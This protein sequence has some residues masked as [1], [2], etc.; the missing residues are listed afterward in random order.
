MV[1]ASTAI[2]DNILE[3][4]VDG[5]S[6]AVRVARENPVHLAITGCPDYLR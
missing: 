2:I 6:P 1:S 4:W 3:G 5:G